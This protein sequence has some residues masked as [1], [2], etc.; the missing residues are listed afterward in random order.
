MKLNGIIMGADTSQGPKVCSSKKAEIALSK[1]KAMGLSK[2]C[3]FSD[4]KEVVHIIKWRVRL[5]H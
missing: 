3:V 5:G 1:A 2:I 4:A